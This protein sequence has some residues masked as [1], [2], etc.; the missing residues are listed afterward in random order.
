MGRRI[1]WRRSRFAR[2][3][4]I[5]GVSISFYP[6]PL[7]LSLSVSPCSVFSG[8]EKWKLP[9]HLST[10][11]DL[12]RSQNTLPWSIINGHGF[13]FFHQKKNQRKPTKTNEKQRKPTKT[14]EKPS[15]SK[16]IWIWGIQ[17]S[18][19]CHPRQV[20]NLVPVNTETQL[21][22]TRIHNLPLS[23]SQDSPAADI[24]CWTAAFWRNWL[25][26]LWRLCWFTGAVTSLTRPQELPTTSAHTHSHTRTHSHTHWH[27]LWQKH[28]VKHEFG[29]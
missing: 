9:Q 17:V 24:D 22:S 2:M 12:K 27:A 11:N 23:E 5:F 21:F 13:R 16:P 26:P 18:S 4:A 19:G 20:S 7:S 29:T 25:N 14:N 15:D 3:M 1:V 8:E 28:E 10:L 6:P